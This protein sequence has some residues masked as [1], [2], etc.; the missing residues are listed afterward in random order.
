LENHLFSR[1][2]RGRSYLM[3][4]RRTKRKVRAENFTIWD[5]C[6]SQRYH[7]REDL[8]RRYNSAIYLVTVEKSLRLIKAVSYT[9]FYQRIIIKNEDFLYFSDG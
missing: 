4:S 6:A 8:V 3:D 5:L 1:E 7:R 2:T 9:L